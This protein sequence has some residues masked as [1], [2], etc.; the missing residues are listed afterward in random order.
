MDCSDPSYRQISASC[1]ATMLLSAVLISIFIATRLSLFGVGATHICERAS[2]ISRCAGQANSARQRFCLI[3]CLLALSITTTSC[4]P[5]ELHS[6]SPILYCFSPPHQLYVFLSM[7]IVFFLSFIIM[8][9]AALWLSCSPS[10]R[11]YHEER[12]AIEACV[13]ALWT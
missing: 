12:Y 9:G 11:V 7:L 4:L 6:I 1:I 3:L 8:C 10:F 2:G 13:H 5:T